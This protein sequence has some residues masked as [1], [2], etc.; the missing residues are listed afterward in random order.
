MVKL[1]D[2][3]SK[4]VGI[5]NYLDKEPHQLSGGQKQS[6]AIAG[7][8]AM[9]QH[10]MIFDEATSMLDPQGKA[11]ISNFI[12]KLNKQYQKTLLTITHDL[13]FAKKADEVIVMN[14]GEIIYHGLPEDV[15]QKVDVLKAIDLD[16]P[17]GLKMVD[18]VNKDEDL[19]KNKRLVESLWQYSLKR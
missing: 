9:N 19:N 11:E 13:E 3:Y 15:F 14:E 8:L 16:I 17:F 12:G 2:K 7:A 18:L 10:I 5:D 4:V 1:V 6:V